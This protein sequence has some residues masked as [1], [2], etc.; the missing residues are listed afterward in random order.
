M[1][2]G[3]AAGSLLSCNFT[4]R[5]Y[6]SQTIGLLKS[7]FFAKIL[8]LDGPRLRRRFVAFMQLHFSSTRKPNYWLAQV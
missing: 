2:P 6:A 7:K 8:R 3:Y 5:P 1:V 4:S